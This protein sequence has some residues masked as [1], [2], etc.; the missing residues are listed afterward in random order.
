MEAT[1]DAAD[2]GEKSSDQEISGKAT[3]LKADLILG[4]AKIQAGGDPEKVAEGL[5]GSLTALVAACAAG[6][7]N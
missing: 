4:S 5:R 7:D 3:V 1:V 6:S 2:E